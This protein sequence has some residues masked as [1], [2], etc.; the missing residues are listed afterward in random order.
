M[1]DYLL[2]VPM[3]Y[4]DAQYGR[5]ETSSPSQVDWTRA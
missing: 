3:I 4:D 1:A 5:F 2:H